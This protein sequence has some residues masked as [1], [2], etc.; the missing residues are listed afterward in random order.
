MINFAAKKVKN[1]VKPL[2]S[3]NIGL[4]LHKVS[5]TRQSE[6]KLSLLSLALLLQ[7]IRKFKKKDYVEPNDEHTGNITIPERTT[8]WTDEPCSSFQ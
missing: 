1:K 2:F 7:K 3:Q 4:P 8:L 6:S 5:G